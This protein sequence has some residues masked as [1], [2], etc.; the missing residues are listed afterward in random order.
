[1]ADDLKVTPLPVSDWDASLATI[2][3]DMGGAPINVHGLMAN[4]PEL[5]KAWWNFRNYSVR[6]G[7]L[8][9]RNGELVIL[10]VAVHVRAWYEWGSHVERSLA[11]GLSLEEIE[12][13]KQGP[14][15]PG[16]A[17]G[18]A[19][20]LAAVDELI[21]THGLA[22]DS[23]ARLRAHFSVQQIMDVMAIHGMYVI[24][25]C[26][27]NT[28]GLELEARVRDKLPDGVTKESFERQFPR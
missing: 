17:A 24:L 27:I 4:H 13:V 6:G 5:L 3:A 8:G 20:L 19:A 12:R 14:A 10:R 2:V 18:E 1:M 22:P 26:M 11:C 15:A 7:A 23:H 16:W 28:W 21:A 25:G 9:R